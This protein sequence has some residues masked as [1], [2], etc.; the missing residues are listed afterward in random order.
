MNIKVTAFTVSEKSSNTSIPITK[1]VSLL[2]NELDFQSVLHGQVS[3]AC[4]NHIC[5]IYEAMNGLKKKILMFIKGLL[6]KC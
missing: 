4:V 2:A 3:L 5:V 6:Q 1:L